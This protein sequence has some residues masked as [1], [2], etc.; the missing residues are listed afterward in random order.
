MATTAV[1]LNGNSIQG[2]NDAG[3]INVDVAGFMLMCGG[4]VTP[5]VSADFSAPGQPMYHYHK[6]PDCTPEF[7]D[8]SVPVDHNGTAKRHGLLFGYV[9]DGFALYGYE[10]LYGNAPVLDE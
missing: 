2:P 5:P 1:H 6:A 4:H 9:L 3:A 8:R 7:L 10:D